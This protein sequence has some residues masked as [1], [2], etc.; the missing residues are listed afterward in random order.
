MGLAEQ[1][2]DGCRLQQAGGHRE[3]G[4][5]RAGPGHRLRQHLLGRRPPEGEIAQRGDDAVRVHE[6]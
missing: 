1:G 2:G 3:V 4:G 5:D 6:Q